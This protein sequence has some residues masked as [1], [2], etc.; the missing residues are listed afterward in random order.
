MCI[1]VLFPRQYKYDLRYIIWWEK[2]QYWISY[3]SCP[4][5]VLDL[6]IWIFTEIWQRSF[7]HYFAYIYPYNSVISDTICY[8]RKYIALKT[9]SLSTIRN[10]IKLNMIFLIFSKP[11]RDN[12]LLLLHYINFMILEETSSRFRI[13]Y[14]YTLITILIYP[15][16]HSD[17]YKIRHIGKKLI[18]ETMIE[19]WITKISNFKENLKKR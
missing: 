8:Q 17:Y 6:P 9:L 14:L 5:I 4:K 13:K 16:E 2:N 12:I 10:I 15:N 7:F 3:S 18:K 1:S 19:I 11:L